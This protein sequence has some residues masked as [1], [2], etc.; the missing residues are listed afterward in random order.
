M[1]ETPLMRTFVYSILI[2]W[3]ANTGPSSA[4]CSSHRN[5]KQFYCS[6]YPIWT[7]KTTERTEFSCK[8]DVVSEMK[9]TFV[10]FNRLYYW[11]GSKV[12]NTMTGKFVAFP[13]EKYRHYYKMKVYIPGILF[14]DSETLQYES[15]DGKCGVFMIA[16]SS[17]RKYT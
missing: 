14:S 6:R 3:S 1:G 15:R 16:S 2:L 17:G 12:N 4:Q 9:Q 10:T 7:I 13:G 5:I 11:H 8:V